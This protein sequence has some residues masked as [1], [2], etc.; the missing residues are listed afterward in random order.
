M[1][2]QTSKNM[3]PTCSILE[4]IITQNVNIQIRTEPTTPLPSI[5]EGQIFNINWTNTYQQ[6]PQNNIR[7]DN[8][9]DNTFIQN[10]PNGKK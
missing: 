10:V 9:G 8:N 7:I 5:G 6:L 2:G 1:F 4:K 3:N